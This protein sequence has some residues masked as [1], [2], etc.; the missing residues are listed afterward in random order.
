MTVFFYDDDELM[1]DSGFIVQNLLPHSPSDNSPEILFMS[2]NLRGN[3]FM[4]GWGS[5]NNYC[6]FLKMILRIYFFDDLIFNAH[7]HKFFYSHNF[8]LFNNRGSFL[9]TMFTHAR[10][11]SE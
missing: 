7:K 9:A 6:F 2:F 3:P 4:G 8:L 5:Q 10:H 11:N 1:S